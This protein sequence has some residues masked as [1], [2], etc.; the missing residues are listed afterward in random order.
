MY[1]SSKHPTAVGCTATILYP[2]TVPPPC[3]LNHPTLLRL[4]YPSKRNLLAPQAPSFEPPFYHVQHYNHLPHEQYNILSPLLYSVNLSHIPRCIIQLTPRHPHSSIFSFDF[5]YSV[6]HHLTLP[7]L[8]TSH[9]HKHTE[10]IRL[11]P[12]IT[13]IAPTTNGYPSHS[14]QIYP[15]ICPNPP[16]LPCL[17]ANKFSITPVS[18]VT[19]TLD[20]FPSY[21]RNLQS[22]PKI[23]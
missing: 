5:S 14:Q 13:L 9:S 18:T 10:S 19:L 16:Y 15:T 11:C 20:P 8:P 6:Q 22:A 2:A 3:R 12:L 17:R 1:S 4:R 21:S 7:C 23:L